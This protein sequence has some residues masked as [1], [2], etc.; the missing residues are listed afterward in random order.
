MR[1]NP[2]NRRIVA[3]V[4]LAISVIAFFYY[5][6][7]EAPSNIDSK[8]SNDLIIEILSLTTAVISMVGSIVSYLSTRPKTQKAKIPKK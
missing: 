3:L 8:G 2:M 5:F 6:T 4:L 7:H 1:E